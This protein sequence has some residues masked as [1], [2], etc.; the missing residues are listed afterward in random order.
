MSGAASVNLREVDLSTRVASFGGVFGG[1]VIPAKKG[2]L[3]EPRLAT[4]DTQLLNVFTPDGR[5]EVGYDLSYFVAL[6]FLERANKLW[7]QRVANSAYFSG[8]IVRDNASAQANEGVPDSSDISDPSAFVLGAEDSFFIHSAN[9]GAWGNEIGIKI[10]TFVE[11]PDDN[12]MTADNE[13]FRLE[14][15]KSSNEVVPV[16]T[17]Y[18]SRVLGKKNGLGQN[19]F[20]EDALEA[21]SYVRAISNDLVDEGELPKPQS[22]ILYLNDGDDGLAVTDANMVTGLNLAFANVEERAVTLIMDG[23]YAVPAYQLAIDTI[24]QN[25]Q[26]CVGILSVPFSDENSA[27]YLN[28]IVDYRKSEL[29]MNSS[30]C[31]LYTPSLRILDRFNDR[32]IWISPVGHV[33][34]SISFSADNFEIWFPPAGFRRG[35][36]N[37]LDTRRR[38]SA[39]EMDVLYNNGINP[40]RFSAGKGIV[41]WGQKTL[42]ARASALD[43]LN[44]RLLLVVIEPAIKEF[45]ENYLFELNDTATRSI[46]ETQLESYLETIRARRGIT[47]YDVVCDDSNNSP[48]DID[49]N[50]LNVDIFIKPSISIEEIPVRVVITPNTISFSDAAGAI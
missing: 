2:P 27:N 30:Y 48:A 21:S 40:I 24:A 4:S 25:R 20:I 46:I 33:C 49:A 39:G 37:V 32:N 18:C 44:V 38:F 29:N 31:A 14:V 47:D 13:I 50:R 12:E 23:G 26:D 1:I 17:F 5:V 43:R 22:A 6:A 41:V 35:I 19:V 9:E 7:V 16:E 34:G 10:V 15:Y 3:D 36:L 42:L 8:A 45:L 11:D 28:D